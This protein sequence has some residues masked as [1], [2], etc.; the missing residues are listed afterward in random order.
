[1]DL[2]DSDDV[3]LHLIDH[4]RD[5]FDVMRS[6]QQLR[7]AFDVVGHDQQMRRIGE[8]GVTGAR[9]SIWPNWAGG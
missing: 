4:L 7:V 3:G 2:I 8:R 9:P 6:L 1:M 5:L